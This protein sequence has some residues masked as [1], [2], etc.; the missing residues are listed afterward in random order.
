MEYS[1]NS[2]NK[3]I[4]IFFFLFLFLF[5][6][7]AAPAQTGND[8]SAVQKQI[9]LLNRQMEEAFN[10]NDMPKVAS[11]Y[12]DDG[13]I[14]YNNNYTVKGRQNLNNYWLSLKDKGRGWKLTVVEIGGGNDFVYQLGKSDLKHVSGD[15]EMNSV[16][17]FVLIWRKQA[18]GNY[19]IFR[20][21]LT[22]TSFKKD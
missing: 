15:R 21:F 7:F 5:R 19:K 1:N 17:N 10:K 14:V 11:F 20:D 9:M 16:T 18:D 12:A 8:S 4:A 3:C 22:K 6:F 13:E 2:L